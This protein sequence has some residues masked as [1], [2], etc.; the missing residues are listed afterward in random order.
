MNKIN[1]MLLI[2][3]GLSSCAS[4]NSSDK[5]KTKPNLLFIQTDQQA[6]FTMKAYGNNVIQTP[7]LD[8]LANKSYVFKKAYCTQAVCSPSR[9]ALLSGLYPHSTGV[10]G[11][12]TMLMNQ[13]SKGIALHDIYNGKETIVTDLDR[14]YDLKTAGLNPILRLIIGKPL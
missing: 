1:L 10:V 6:Y 13:S 8:K 7:A 2:C 9:S 5:D 3:L 12:K 4:A 14:F 11:N